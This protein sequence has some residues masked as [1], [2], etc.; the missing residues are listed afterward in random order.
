MH[1]IY[2]TALQSLNELTQ[3]MQNSLASFLEDCQQSTFWIGHTDEVAV[4]AI[5][6]HETKNEVLLEVHI[7]DADGQTLDVE[8]TQET[9]AGKM[10]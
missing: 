10:A 2:W 4:A 9:A 6:I 3:F 1:S 5:A 7:P 8:L